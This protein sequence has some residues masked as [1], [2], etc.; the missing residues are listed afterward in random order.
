MLAVQIPHA[1]SWQVL[2]LRLEPN[3]ELRLRQALKHMES[4]RASVEQCATIRAAVAGEAHG[5]CMGMDG[6]NREAGFLDSSEWIGLSLLLPHAFASGGA[7]LVFSC[8][9]PNEHSDPAATSPVTLVRR[10]GIRGR[11]CDSGPA[12]TRGAAE[13]DYAARRANGSRYGWAK[14]G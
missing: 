6:E 2:R 11:R 13:P 5:T 12:I 14:T 1:Q 3:E 8:V 7:G 10:A 4:R 9:W